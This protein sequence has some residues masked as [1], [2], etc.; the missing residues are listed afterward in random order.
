M[1]GRFSLLLLVGANLLPLAGVFLWDWDVFLLLLLFWC[2]NVI[3]G[4]FGIAR[5]VVA[6]DRDTIVSGLFHPLFFLVHYG[7]FMFGHFMVLF[8]MYANHMEDLGNSASPADYY[9]LVVENLN[10]VA[11]AGLFVSHGWS[12]VENFMG[13]NEYERLSP[14]QAMGLPYKRMVITHVALIFGG[15]FLIKQGQPLAGLIL[16]V[17]LK[18]A[19][20]VTFHR[21]EHRNLGGASPGVE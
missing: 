3:I 16:L 18:I 8:G 4:L 10:W 15:F 11:I 20:D 2:E 17:I 6:A 12:F 19:L 14:M 9:T 7:G 21:R 5:L 1:R 13:R